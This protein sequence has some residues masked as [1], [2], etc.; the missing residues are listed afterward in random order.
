MII[1]FFHP[2]SLVF[3]QETHAYITFCLLRTLFSTV[4]DEALSNSHL[5]DDLSKVNDWAYKREMCFNPGSTKPAHEVVFSR[6]KRIFTTLRLHLTNFLL[7]AFNLTN[8]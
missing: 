4:T 7:S 2:I 8:I 3:A 6:K 1:I 5:N